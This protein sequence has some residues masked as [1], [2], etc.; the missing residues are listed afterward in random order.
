M[1]EI[2]PEMERRMQADFMTAFITY[3]LAP[4]SV[5]GPLWMALI[6]LPGLYILHREYRAG[7]IKGWWLWLLPATVVP[8]SVLNL[9]A[10]ELWDACRPFL[11]LAMP[12]MAF[13]GWRNLKYLRPPE[14]PIKWES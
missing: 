8:V 12:V 2:T 1:S 4:V 7:R 9:A 10:P 13:L 5:S 6:L 11:I 14:P 3:M